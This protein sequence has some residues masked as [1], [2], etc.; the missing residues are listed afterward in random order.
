MMEDDNKNNREVLKM[1]FFQVVSVEQAKEKLMSHFPCRSLP[2]ET[3]SILEASGRILGETIRSEEDIPSFIRSTVDGYAIKSSNSHGA[4]EMTPGFLKMIG[5]VN[6]GETTPLGIS[7][8]Q[9]VY[10][11][12]GGMIPRGADAV[13]MIEYAERLSIESITVGKPLSVGENIVYPGDDIK[14]GAIVL[15]AGRKITPQDIGL[16]AA[17]GIHEVPVYNKPGFYL[18]S[19][20]DEIIDIQ[21]KMAPG[22]IRD[23]NGYLLHA[24]IMETGGHVVGRSLI[25][26]D[27]DQLKEEIQK[28][29]FADAQVI[30][31]SG[32]SSV[33]ER[34]FTFDAINSSGGKGVFVH[35]I[36]IKPGKPTIIGEAGGKALFGLPGHPVSAVIIFKAFIEFLIR[37]MMGS[38]EKQ[39]PFCKA[40]T[41]SNFHSDPGKETYQMVSLEKKNG[42]IYARPVFGKSGMISLLLNSSGYIVIGSETEGL[43]KGCEVD[44]FSI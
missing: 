22:K 37:H 44:V 19:T 32:G 24:L 9:A 40:V 28:A 35:G 16:L 30:L 23:I 25:K 39:S 29:L 42:I 15:E 31:I 27:A 5:E 11:P 12:T 20:G 10:V 4:N 7:D 14:S 17:L 2:L 21:D 33:G 26:D 6:M 13:L 34:D 1:D 41:A 18:I 3:V 8:G 36:S 38:H 43:P